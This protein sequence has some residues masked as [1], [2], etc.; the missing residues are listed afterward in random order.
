MIRRLRA[1]HIAV[2]AAGLL[3]L[4]T[5]ASTP[6]WMHH[7]VDLVEKESELAKLGPELTRDAAEKVLGP[8]KHAYPIPGGTRME[9]ESRKRFQ[10][11]LGRDTL[12]IDFNQD[13]SCFQHYCI[14]GD[15]EPD[16]WYTV[17]SVLTMLKL[18]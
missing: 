9:W 15:G 3:M 7:D 4:L 1:W 10:G 16:L 2:L 17:Q 11:M 12:I 6:L 13:G 5:A 14:W 18:V 8:P